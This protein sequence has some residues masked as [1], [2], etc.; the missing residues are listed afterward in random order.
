MNKEIGH[1]TD[2]YPDFMESPVRQPTFGPFYDMY[3]EDWDKEL[4][5][6]RVRRDLNNIAKG[7]EHERKDE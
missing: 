7:G 4:E 5:L 6:A 2:I 3:K 1:P